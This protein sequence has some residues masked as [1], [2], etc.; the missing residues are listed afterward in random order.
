MIVFEILV[1]S[2]IKSYKFQVMDVDFF[3]VVDT[4]LF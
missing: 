1:N 2:F 3:L 4:P